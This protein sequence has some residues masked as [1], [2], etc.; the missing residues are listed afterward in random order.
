MT[1]PK[2]DSASC[3]GL[4]DY[5]PIVVI[6]THE[7]KDITTRNIN[8]LKAQSFL[9]KIVIVC[10]DHQE[11][12]YYKTLGVSVMLEPNRPLGKKWQAGVN[13]A[14][15]MG[16]N[17]LVILGS[18]DILSKDYV[19]LSLQK[20]R[21]GFDFIGTTHWVSLEPEKKQIYHSHYVGVNE[22]YPIG[23]GKVYSKRLLD[24]IG[25]LVFDVKAEKR[26]DDNGHKMI[27]NR[28]PKIF[29][30]KEPMI[31]AVKGNWKQLNPFDKYLNVP[32]IKS[33]KIKEDILE[34][35]IW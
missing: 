10:S 26:L 22:N 25:N 16:A 20:L 24:K 3:C 5:N 18:D 32:T 28:N 6:A 11:L 2:D 4:C 33:V 8:S 17:P 34:K 13:L 27:T 7:R 1:C 23:S 12:E 21:E 30:F 29:L 14:V 15:K 31:L 19:K 35:F 9:P